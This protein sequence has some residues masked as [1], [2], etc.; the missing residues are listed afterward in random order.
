[1]LHLFSKAINLLAYSG[2]NPT[3]TSIMFSYIL[4]QTDG[5]YN[6]TP[7]KRSTK[8]ALVQGDRPLL[9]KC[10]IHFSIWTIFRA[11]VLLP[12]QAGPEARLASGQPEKFLVTGCGQLYNN[13][14][15]YTGVYSLTSFQALRN[16]L[17]S[18]KKMNFIVR[19][20]EKKNYSRVSFFNLVLRFR[21]SIF[22]FSN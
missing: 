9:R 13:S 20:L 8:P 5:L 4:V 21:S 16:I 10:S 2:V 14:Y 22:E 18:R 11:M 6:K 17:I 7:Y 12:G 15:E 3:V 19:A 1:M